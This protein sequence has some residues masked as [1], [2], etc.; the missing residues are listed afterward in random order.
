MCD[1]DYTA[2]ENHSMGDKENDKAN[3]VKI[4]ELFTHTDMRQ[5][6]YHKYLG[7]GNE[8]SGEEPVDTDDAIALEHDSVYETVV[9]AEDI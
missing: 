8:L 5:L 4:E 7:L 2:Y 6:P 1:E 9:S 3:V